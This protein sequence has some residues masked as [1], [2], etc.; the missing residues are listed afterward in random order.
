MTTSEHRLTA[1]CPESPTGRHEY[2][3]DWPSVE[4]DLRYLA[5]GSRAGDPCMWCPAD[6]P[7]Q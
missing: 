2:D 4:P 7:A 1:E 6:K 5:P 3:D